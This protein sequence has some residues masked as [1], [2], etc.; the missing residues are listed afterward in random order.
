M[1]PYGVLMVVEVRIGSHPQQQ[2]LDYNFAAQV[3]VR[4]TDEHMTVS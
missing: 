1:S 2:L 3:S 4:L